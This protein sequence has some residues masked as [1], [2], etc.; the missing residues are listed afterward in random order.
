M[1]SD[2]SFSL[3][4]SL[5]SSGL[6]VL[7]LRGFCLRS[8]VSEIWLRRLRAAVLVR[9]KARACGLE[10]FGFWWAME[11]IFITAWGEVQA[12]GEGQGETIGT[13]LYISHKLI[14]KAP[15]A[16]SCTKV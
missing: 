1:A 7:A 3:R 6:R 5:R 4:Q 10:A 14:L 13:K 8:E 9:L 12:I 15:L 16:H 11:L 2:C